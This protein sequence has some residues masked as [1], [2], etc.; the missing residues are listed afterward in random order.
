MKLRTPFLFLLLLVSG[1]CLADDVGV[2]EVRLFEE[3]KNIYTLEADVS[4]FLI[5]TIQAPV[6]PK[7]FSFIGKTERVPVGQLLVVRYRFSSRGRPIY[8]VFYVLSIQ[9]RMFFQPCNSQVS[10]DPSQDFAHP[11]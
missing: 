6:L 3:D 8:R 1:A 9:H 5:N 7:S 4:P 11:S 2:T 10:A